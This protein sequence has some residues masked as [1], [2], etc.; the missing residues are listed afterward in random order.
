M[1]SLAQIIPSSATRA[2]ALSTILSKHPIF[3]ATS[4]CAAALSRAAT[5][6]HPSAPKSKSRES[7]SSPS[8]PNNQSLLL[9]KFDYLNA[10]LGWPQFHSSL[11]PCFFT[12][13]LL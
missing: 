4:G 13:L 8:A 1:D 2:A 12:S 10:T 6:A 7:K 11:P 9:V 3:P 5:F